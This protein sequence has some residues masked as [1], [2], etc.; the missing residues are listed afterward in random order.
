MKLRILHLYD[1]VMNLYGEYA[2]VAILERFWKSL[3]HEV[4]VDKLAL[5]EE[6]DIAGYDLYYMGAGTERKMKRVLPQLV[7]YREALEAACEAGKVLL[8]TGNACDALGKTVTDCDGKCYE[9][10]GIGDFETEEVK[11]RTTG[12]CIA[13][14]DGFAEP[15]VGFINKCSKNT[16]IQSSL[17]TMQMGQGNEKGG[18]A[19]GFRRNNC[20]GTHI[21]GPVLVKNPAMLRYVTELVLGKLPE[22]A[23]LP[24]FTEESYK[25]TKAELFKRM[26]SK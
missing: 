23:A 9:A 10:L 17:F 1:D 19:E 3:G 13:K 4:T 26:E 2:N 11:V 15:L 12:D 7:K 22:D 16:G 20:L 18:D 6:A 8:F 25:I 5:Y 14:F 24:A 21:T